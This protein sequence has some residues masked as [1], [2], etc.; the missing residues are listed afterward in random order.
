MPKNQTGLE[1]LLK[2][3][4]DMQ[5]I[6]IKVID[7]KGQTAITDYMIICSGRASRHVKAIADQVM[8]NMKAAG[9][10]ALNHNGLESSD[11]ALLDFGDYIVHI[12]QPECRSFY[13]LEELWQEK[14]A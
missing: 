8:L 1:T 3:L 4:D 10:P 7:V 2:A 11:W 5:A 9:I 14:H 13:N 12:M 6:D